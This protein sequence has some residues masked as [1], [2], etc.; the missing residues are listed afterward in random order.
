MKNWLFEM[1]KKSPGGERGGGG[2]GVAVG[3]GGSQGEQTIE[4]IVNAIKKRWW[5][6]RVDVNEELKLL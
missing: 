1:K 5:G 2:G 3:G 6:F 4:V